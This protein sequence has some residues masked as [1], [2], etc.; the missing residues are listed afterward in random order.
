MLLAVMCE[1]L[2]RLMGILLLKLVAAWF[3]LTTAPTVAGEDVPDL[4]PVIEAHGYAYLE[5]ASGVQALS[6]GAWVLRVFVKGD[7]YQSVIV[8]TDGRSVT[9]ID[10]P[11]RGGSG[12][13]MQLL[14]INA[15]GRDDLAVNEYQ[16]RLRPG[17]LDP[18]RR[19][20]DDLLSQ[21]A[22]LISDIFHQPFIKNKN[23]D[24]T[25]VE[26]YEPDLTVRV[27]LGENGNAFRKVF[28]GKAVYPADF[29]DGFGS[30]GVNL[31]LT[32]DPHNLRYPPLFVREIHVFNG[33]TF[34]LHE[35]PEL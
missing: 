11:M 20:K 10:E 17:A 31:V 2:I 34:V 29:L 32:V 12:I 16:G 19:N 4:R 18:S 3:F 22:K 13:K 28:Q 27:F 9:A 24:W 15:D 7:T 33:E 35:L 8:V 30:S 14:D 26:Y 23:D 6:S 5:N 25:V 21:G 1:G